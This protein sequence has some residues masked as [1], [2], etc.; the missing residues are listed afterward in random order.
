MNIEPAC[1]GYQDERFIMIDQ[2][3]MQIPGA[4]ELFQMSHNYQTLA[5]VF[6]VI[7]A[8]LLPVVVLFAATEDNISGTF[9]FLGITEIASWTSFGLCTLLRRYYENRFRKFVEEAT[10]LGRP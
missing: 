5:R 3:N 1:G 2:E 10:T 6:G 8:G 4:C 7:G 9:L